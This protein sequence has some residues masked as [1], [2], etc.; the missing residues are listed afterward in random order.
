MP[1]ERRWIVLG[2]DGRHVTIG[3]HT[4]PSEEEL[5]RASDSLRAIGVGGWVAV[6]EGG[7]YQP[8]DKISLMM[9]REIAP[10]RQPWEAAVSS[11]LELRT[12]A[13]SLPSPPK[14]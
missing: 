9:V 1:R 14:P 4:D 3:R 11:F 12:H 7:Y 5:A 6:L 8:R 2:D 13:L 10:A